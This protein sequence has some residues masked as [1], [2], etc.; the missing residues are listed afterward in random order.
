MFESTV[1]YNRLQSLQRLR[2]HTTRQHRPIYVYRP[3]YPPGQRNWMQVTVSELVPGDVVSC[4]HYT[5]PRGRNKRSHQQE[6][7]L[8][9]IPADILVL[10]GDAVVDEAL[11]TGESIPKYNL[12]HH[13][14]CNH[15]HLDMFF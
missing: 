11:L 5:I 4:K 10:S 7:Q 12:A 2:S 15:S 8:N 13:R 14:R 3:G 9:T 1:A 6:Q